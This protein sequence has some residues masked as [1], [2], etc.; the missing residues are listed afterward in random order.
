MSLPD[1]GR[2]LRCRQVSNPNSPTHQLANSPTILPGILRLALGYRF[3]RSPRTGKLNRFVRPSSLKK[4]RS[5]IRPKTK[6]CNGF[7]METIIESIN[8]SLKGWYG[9]FKHAHTSNMKAVDGWVR[10]RLRSIIRKRKNRK[11]RGRGND[12]VQYPNKY[13]HAAGLFSLESARK[14]EIQSLRC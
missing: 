1:A 9:Y 5:K 11:G 7:A 2:Q 14:A 13:F 12:H 6:R 3:Q 4:I 10:M 8:P